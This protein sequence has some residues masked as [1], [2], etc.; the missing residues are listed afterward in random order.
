MA[1]YKRVVSLTF[2][3]RTYFYAI[4]I[5]I[6]PAGE[7]PFFGRGKVEALLAW[8]SGCPLFIAAV[9]ITNTSVP[10]IVRGSTL[11]PAKASI[12]VTLVSVIGSICLTRY[13]SSV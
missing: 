6:K 5:A 8:C 3:R 2:C 10:P 1:A 4:C 12:D 13:L 11:Q 7:E 9:M